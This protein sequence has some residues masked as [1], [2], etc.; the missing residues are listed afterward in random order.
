[1]NHDLFSTHQSRLADLGYYTGIIDGDWGPLTELAFIRFKEAHGFWARPYPGPQTLT[2]LWS[3]DA[4]P[5]ESPTGGTD[6][7]WIQEAVRLI[8]TEEALGSANNPVI[9]SWAKDL[10]QW[11]PSDTTAWCGLFVAHCMKVGS[12]DTQNFN[13]LAARQWLNYGIKLKEPRLGC[14]AVF[15]REMPDS[16]KGHVGFL[17]GEDEQAWQVLGGNQSDSV[18]V[19]RISKHRALGFRWPKS[20]FF[21]SDGSRRPF[22]SV[23]TAGLS[24]N[25]V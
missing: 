24:T 11:Y 8:G 23:T 7:L 13:R 1:M 5:Y 14:I 3:P 22:P 2:K 15:W 4:R 25:E 17:V 18:N 6:P 21:I 16:W 20:A 10:D 19:I 12:N 9:L